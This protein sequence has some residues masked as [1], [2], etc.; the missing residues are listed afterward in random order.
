MIAVGATTLLSV[1]IASAAM[2][3]TDAMMKDPMASTSM[4][5]DDAATKTDTM[6]KSD[7]MMKS[8]SMMTA[9]A[10]LTIGSHGAGVEMLQTMLIE[11]GFL[12]IPAGV[13]KGYFGPLTKEAL[14]KYQASLGVK[15]TG[16]YGPLTRAAVH[17]MMMKSDT[18][19][20]TN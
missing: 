9:D 18:M 4:M 7:A 10:D 14:K 8:D 19:K 16:Y 2:M 15:A 12:N 1:N 20:P 13:S 5:H 11:K 6:M 3:G 17:T